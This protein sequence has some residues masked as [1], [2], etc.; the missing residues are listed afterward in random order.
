MRFAVLGSGSSGNACLIEAGGVRVLVDAGLSA[1]QLGE[2]M[3]A[4]GLCASQLD[5]ILLTH[6]HIDHVK[7]LKVLLKKHS[8]V[9]V[10]ATA[11]TARVVRETGVAAGWK[12]FEAGNPFLIGELMVESFSIQHDAVDPVGYVFRHNGC[13][14]GLL[15]DAGHVTASV[16]ERLRGVHSLFVEANYDEDMLV[17]DTKRP[18][19]LKQR[20]SSR[21]GH[22]SNKQ[23]AELIAELAHP[24]LARVVLGHISR[25]CNRPDV[26]LSVIRGHLA[27]CCSHSFEIQCAAADE[28][29][30][31][32]PFMR[33]LAG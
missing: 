19:S 6:E 15:S 11:P 13:S 29:S 26:A 4:R 8:G 14:M 33:E 1:K 23:T 5:A 9:P 20:I 32:W 7:G 10:Y 24:A 28:P 27:G 21:H 2:R 12:I 3:A 18:W 31:W 30:P 16:I 25:D 17:A 22:L